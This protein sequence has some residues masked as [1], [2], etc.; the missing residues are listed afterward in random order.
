MKN[1]IK[2]ILLFLVIALLGSNS[3]DDIVLPIINLINEFIVNSDT[4][5]DDDSAK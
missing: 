1:Q 2:T 5:T 4:A 3:D